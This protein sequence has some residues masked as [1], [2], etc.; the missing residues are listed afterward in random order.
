MAKT[1]P[2]QVVA[3]DLPAVKEYVQ[4]LED[5]CLALWAE[6]PTA[7]VKTMGVEQPR[8]VNFMQRL[9]ET[10]EHEQARANYWAED[11]APN[12]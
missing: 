2:I 8:L 12:D 7:E 3:A 10:Y 9:H 11:G 4:M 1:G 6:L 5:A